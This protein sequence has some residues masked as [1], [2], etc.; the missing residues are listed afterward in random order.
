M[1]GKLRGWEFNSRR[2]WFFRTSCARILR[3]WP[4]LEERIQWRIM[5]AVSLFC[6][7]FNR[8]LLRRTVVELL[9]DRPTDRPLPLCCWRAGCTSSKSGIEGGCSCRR[10]ETWS[11][12]FDWIEVSQ[13]FAT[14]LR[15]GNKIHTSDGEEKRRTRREVLLCVGVSG[16]MANLCYWRQQRGRPCDEDGGEQ[17]WDNLSRKV[18]SFFQL[19]DSLDLFVFDW[20]K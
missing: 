1:N 4:W 5:V 6:G 8:A 12:R 3:E 11:D 17:F 13:L 9:I 7:L 16:G 20:Q 10:R 19:S 14:H 2:R 18:S 15:E